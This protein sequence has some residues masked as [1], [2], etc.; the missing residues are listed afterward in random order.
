MQKKIKVG[1]MYSENDGISP[2]DS[3]VTGWPTGITYAS[4]IEGI[5]SEGGMP[6]NLKWDDV[7]D[8]LKVSRMHNLSN[9][10]IIRNASIDYLDVLCFMGFGNVLEVREN[11]KD[12]CK[13]I[14]NLEESGI[15]PTINPSK[16]VL[17]AREGKKRYLVDLFEN[18]I[19]VPD[20]YIVDS[21]SGVE[22]ISSELVDKYGGY[23]TKPL[24]GFGGFGVEKFPGGDL[25]SVKDILSKDG[26]IIVQGYVNNIQETGERSVFIFGD[27]IKYTVLKKS[28]GFKTNVTGNIS[29]VSRSLV[30]CTSAE[31]K[32]AYEAKELI[33]PEALIARAD[34]IGDRDNP[35][36][37]ELT[38]SS[39]GLHTAV[40]GNG[41]NLSVEGYIKLIENL[42]R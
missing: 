11:D 15:V 41:R 38:L 29:G 37:G 40:F 27:D 33:A 2:H 32:L 30:D 6:Y 8:N 35:Y 21:L 5:M 39:I 31:R 3:L 26:E 18:G 16:T 28:S 7:G 14:R 19:S 9:P 20:T 4:I 17:N 36:V 1:F 42:V 24:N 25:E 12:L 13:V 10:E 22:D 23:V 34:L